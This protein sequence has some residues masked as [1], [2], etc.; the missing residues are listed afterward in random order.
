MLILASAIG[1]SYLERPVMSNG[2]SFNVGTI[3]PV[4]KKKIWWLTAVR[5]PPS[6][7]AM[8]RGLMISVTSLAVAGGVA[9]SVAVGVSNH[10]V[11]HR[12]AAD[13][14]CVGCVFYHA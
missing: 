1:G 9:A 14:T 10:P 8:R 6:A 5:F 11:Q 4:D 2:N 13:Q 7:G 12:F 3:E